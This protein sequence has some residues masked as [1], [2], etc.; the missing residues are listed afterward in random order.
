MMWWWTNGMGW[1]GW[2]LMVLLMAAFWGVVL[3]GVVA[4][5]RTVGT[6][7]QLPCGTDATSRPSAKTILDE[8]FARGE[9]DA[10][11]YRIRRDQLRTGHDR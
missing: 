4:L 9:I 1:G 3:V 5:F 7:R 11:E 6:G 2:V 8:R 10:E